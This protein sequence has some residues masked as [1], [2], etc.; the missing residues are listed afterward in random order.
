[1]KRSA[2]LNEKYF[3]ADRNSSTVLELRRLYR[4]TKTVK[5]LNSAL[6]SFMARY[7]TLY[8]NTNLLGQFFPRA[9]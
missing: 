7:F 9:S 5:I 6:D 3:C 8:S 2:V 1:V 4:F